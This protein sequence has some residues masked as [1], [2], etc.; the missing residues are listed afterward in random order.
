MNTIKNWSLILLSIFFLPPISLN[1]QTGEK[2][3]TFVK[4]SQS[5]K[6]YERKHEGSGMKEIRL[7]TTIDRDIK[8]VTEY[9]LNI[10]KY[11]DWVYALSE[12]YTI[13][14]TS[15]NEQI[16]YTYTK[17]PSLFNDRDI[18]T[19]SNW[20]ENPKTKCVTIVSKAL[21][22]S[23]KY[24]PLRADV[25]RMTVFETTCMLTPKGTGTEFEYCA[26]THPGGSMPVWVVNLFVED[27]PI[28]SVAKLKSN[29]KK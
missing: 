7:V 22:D 14:N 12:A 16:I 24:K 10:A 18:V 1:A 4:E 6:V 25:V 19:K 21:T 13:K 29:L 11:K 2:S 9:F 26:L 5:V 28:K 3:W 8:D 20:S 23:Q 17:F 15:K 27:G